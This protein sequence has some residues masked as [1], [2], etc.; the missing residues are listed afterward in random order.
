MCIR[1][2]RCDGGFLLRHSHP[3]RQER[4]R[5]ESWTRKTQRFRKGTFEGCIARTK[6]LHQEG[7]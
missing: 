1:P 6:G 7:N 2:I 3:P 5:E 4:N